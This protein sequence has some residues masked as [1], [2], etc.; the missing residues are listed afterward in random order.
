[1]YI[2]LD[3]L[4]DSWYRINPQTFTEAWKLCVV[5]HL[6]NVIH[7]LKYAE[8]INFNI[9]IYWRLQF[10]CT[11]F[12]RKIK[13]WFDWIEGS[14][15]ICFQ[16]L[17]RMILVKGI[18]VMLSFSFLSIWI[19]TPNRQPFRNQYFIELQWKLLVVSCDI[20]MLVAML[21]HRRSYHIDC[22]LFI[23]NFYACFDCYFIREIIWRG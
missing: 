14:E 16:F 5:K 2:N 20:Y 18:L 12:S 17:S 23:R 1:M 21:W 3:A 11:C 7:L 22:S 19:S 15:F 9:F 13:L 10:R 4:L 6:Q 8:Y